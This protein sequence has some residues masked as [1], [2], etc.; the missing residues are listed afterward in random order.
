MTKLNQA[1][2]GQ[3]QIPDDFVL[4]SRTDLYG[5][6]TDA[7]E[8]FAAVCGFQ[9]EQLIGQPHNIIRHP[10]VP[11]EAFRDLWTTLKQGRSWQCIVKN[12]SRN[13]GHYWVVANA[14]PLRNEN[15]NID[16]YISVRRPASA[17]DIA[18]A[19]N[20]YPKL[21]NGT[22]K[23]EGG[24][25]ISARQL[26]IER[27]NPFS[28]LRHLRIQTKANILAA[29]LL[30]PLALLTFF[31]L[32]YIDKNITRMWQAQTA[33]AIEKAAQ[34][35]LHYTQPILK[36]AIVVAQN[37]RTFKKLTRSL[38]NSPHKTSIKN[39]LDAYLKSNFT[40]GP[41]GRDTLS[42]LS[43]RFYDTK[44]NLLAE[45]RAPEIPNRYQSHE[46]M[47][48]ALQKRIKNRPKDKRFQPIRYLHQFNQLPVF[49]VIMPVGGLRLQGYLELAVNAAHNI[50]AIANIIDMPIDI[51]YLDGKPY[52]QSKHWENKTESEEIYQT[53]NRVLSDDNGS[54]LLQ[55]KA[56]QNI[57]DFANTLFRT[58]A[59]VMGV[60]A[61][62]LIL[63]AL[64]LV[65]LLRKALLPVRK[66]QQ[67]MKAGARGIFDNRVMCRQ[68]NDELGQTVDDY[69]GL[70]NAAQLAIVSV[71]QVLRAL[72]QG[73]LNERIQYTAAGDLERL[74][75]LTNNS[76]EQ[77]DNTFDTISSGMHAI[78]EG[79]FQQPPVIDE[80]VEGQFKTLLEEQTHVISQMNQMVTELIQ[81]SEKMANGELSTQIEAQLPGDLETLKQAF[82]HG[83]SDLN[84]AIQSVLTVVSAQSQGDLTQTIT[85]ECRGDLLTMKNAINQSADKL[86]Q[87][88]TNAKSIATQVTTASQEVSQGAMDLSD[89][90]QQQAAAV[91]ETTAS[92]EQI[93][94]TVK[95]NANNA[96]SAVASAHK[97]SQRTH[98]GNQTMQ[99]TISAMKKIQASSH[100]IS[101]I[102]TLIDSI[103][104]QTNLL[105]LNAAV[106]AA[107][108]GE[109]GRGFAVV[110]GEVRSLAQKSSDAA[111]EIREL[112]EHS[113]E[114]IN[115]G[116]KLAS[117]SGQ[118][119]NEISD[120]IEA[121][122][123]TITYIAEA[124]MEQ[125][126]GIDQVHKAIAE[127]DQSTQQNAAL[128]EQ[129]SAA[130]DH[131][132]D[133]AHQL[134]E[135]MAFFHIHD[136][137][138]SIK[139]SFR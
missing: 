137:H 68:S 50:K 106:E 104:F 26:R 60:F 31:S 73:N 21:K 78:A 54:P 79:R 123:T 88:V 124:S 1:A 81:A 16:E 57:T 92:M 116:T 112:I 132:K 29:L 58:E 77:L 138:Q 131:L 95:E 74:K 53:V 107:R 5:T 62:A 40:G 114:A 42:G 72:S 49:S 59:I 136:K 135:D 2:D 118:S 103:A 65:F 87:I 34:T 113:V 97:T 48:L 51:H 52:F 98:E 133:Q 37:T 63:F 91:E 56:K 90:V 134:N 7:S 41:F 126:Y 82:N 9:R 139:G 84:Q 70:M 19:K 120:A 38:L 110:A 61:T 76:L 18:L 130:S 33:N 129:T 108:A 46:P 127:V 66:M 47:P 20:L 109:H 28:Y 22:M 10:D 25:P 100:Q 128:V 44:L 83:L 11:A 39:K 115:H 24:V 101:E 86:K 6:I 89:R 102:V 75:R 117:H 99:K 35:E 43:F 17:S 13:G 23:L 27:Y 80:S 64:T 36:E 93:Q 94:N 111:R 3:I 4:T 45:G 122:S 69:N 67:A 125:S 15:G 71:S 85:L 55:I 8:D 32:Q 121:V 12:R 14:S 30:V 119:L 96:Q 105:A